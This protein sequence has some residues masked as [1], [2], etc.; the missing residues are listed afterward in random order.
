MAEY[1]VEM[2]VVVVMG[3]VVMEYFEVEAVEKPLSFDES[4]NENFCPQIYKNV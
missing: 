3:Y 1:V 4:K 2:N